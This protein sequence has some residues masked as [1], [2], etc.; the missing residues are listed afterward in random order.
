[1][2]QDI[3][4][5]VFKRL[6]LMFTTTAGQILRLLFS[7]EATGANHCLVPSL[8]LFPWDHG[9]EWR[10]NRETIF[11]LV[12]TSWLLSN[13]IWMSNKALKFFPPLYG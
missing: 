10:K 5:N 12:R 4:G 7:L 6:V 3:K 9:L 13:L 11:G 8:P 1:M 2:Y